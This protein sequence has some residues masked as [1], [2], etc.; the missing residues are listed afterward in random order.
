MTVMFQ[1]TH[2]VTGAASAADAT[3]TGTLYVNGAA[4]AAAV[5]VTQISGG[6][7]KAAV[8]LPVLA[9]GDVVSLH[10]AAAVATVAGEAIVYQDTADTALESDTY[11]RLGAPA[12]ASVSADIAA[13][14]T[15]ADVNAACDS[16]I[17]D[18]ALA[19]AA[20]LS[21]LH[22]DV[23]TVKA[24]T[25]LMTSASV[26]VTSPVA[27]DGT[28][29]TIYSGDSY[30]LVHGRGGIS[31]AVTDAAHDLDLDAVTTAVKLKCS[32]ATWTA[33]S[34]TSTGTGYTLLWTPTAAETALITADQT[35]EVEATYTETPPPDN[36]ATLVRGSIVCV[37]DIPATS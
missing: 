16:A 26:T 9:A 28:T 5:T 2:P 13:L 21:D 19:T 22:T 14:P 20:S 15:D 4:D 24:K 34:V 36:V 3:P 31:I 7:Y 33:A 12:G 29:I 11:A 10:V 32:Q 17:A 25:D 1:A 27:T 18:A 30:P 35:Y 8:T 37:R 23:G 6:R